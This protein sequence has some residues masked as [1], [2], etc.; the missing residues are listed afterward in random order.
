MGFE[1]TSFPAK[2]NSVARSTSCSS[3]LSVPVFASGSV[4]AWLLPL[5]SPLCRALSLFLDGR[6]RAHQMPSFFFFE[7]ALW[8][9][10]GGLRTRTT[11]QL[12]VWKLWSVPFGGDFFSPFWSPPNRV[13][14]FLSSIKRNLPPGP[15]GDGANC[16]LLRRRVI[17]PLV[18]LGPDHRLRSFFSSPPPFP[19]VEKISFFAEEPVRRGSPPAERAKPLLPLTFHSLCVLRDVGLFS[20]SPRA[21]KPFSDAI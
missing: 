11:I 13:G 8:I 7:E 21:D 19:A 6:E 16:P 15:A 2:K 12:F 5:P 4:W 1:R 9:I 20:F 17:F 14:T 3:S 10:R 18:V